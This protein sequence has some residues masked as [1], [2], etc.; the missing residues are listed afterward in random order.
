[1]VIIT[2]AGKAFQAGADIKQLSEMTPLQLVRWNEG[3]VRNNAALE[4]LRQ[5][6]IA[7][8]NGAAMGGG[9]ELALGCTLRVAS[10]KAALALPEV[11]LGIIPGAGGT[12]R[13]PRLIGKGR[14]MKMILTG[15][16]VGAEEALRIGLLDEV[17]APD[18][19][20]RRH[21][22]KLLD[23]RA[24]LK[25]LAR[26]GDNHHVDFFV[27]ADGRHGLGQLRGHLIADGVHHV[28]SVQGDGG[29]ALIF[30]YNNRTVIS[31]LTVSFLNYQS[32][33][34]PSTTTAEPVM[35]LDASDASSTATP[36][37]SPGLPSRFIGILRLITPWPA[38]DEKNLEFIGVS[39]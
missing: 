39:I 13:L 9:L 8:I 37:I 19:L 26:A 35:K 3:L 17:A 18:E 7:A 33:L 24:G 16:I 20:Q 14:A 10:E 29:D 30:F 6:V 1:V 25:R 4:K 36:F 11:N 23:I 22:R 38:S 2:G 15:Q 28:R 5:P 21:L 12:Q 32:T 34:P 27:L 31:H